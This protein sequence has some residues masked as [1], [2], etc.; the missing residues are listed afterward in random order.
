MPVTAGGNVFFQ[1]LDRNILFPD[2]GIHDITNRYNACQFIMVKYWNMPDMLVG[3]Y[4]HKLQGGRFRF[5]SC[6]LGGHVIFHLGFLGR[7][8]MEYD[9]ACIIPL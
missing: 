2:D 8:T 1:V 5:G 6:Q 3:H 7:F 9:L 4:G